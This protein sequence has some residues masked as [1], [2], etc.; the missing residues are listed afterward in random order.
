VPGLR[1]RAHPARTR[2]EGG[3]GIRD[4]AVPLADRLPGGAGR[5]PRHGAG[6]RQAGAVYQGGRQRPG[7][8]PS[9]DPRRP[10]GI[11]RGRPGF[12]PDP[13][14]EREHR[15][16]LA[17]ARCRGVRVPVGRAGRE[18][19][20]VTGRHGLG[21]LALARGTLDRLTER[22]SDEAWLEKA[23]ADPRTRVLTVDDGRASVRFGDD[24]DATLV[25]DSPA[26]VSP[27]AARYLLG[28]DSD[29]VVY[30][31]VH[32]TLR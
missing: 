17:A 23:W 11:H 9:R 6:V 16:V 8:R 31:A 29:G 1:A 30:F 26:D 27:D 22:R 14:A 4:P 19:V 15:H 12:R 32:D 10:A 25:L 20:Q 28:Q 3:A 5:P 24:E 18:R 21:R 7:G 13:R 2:C